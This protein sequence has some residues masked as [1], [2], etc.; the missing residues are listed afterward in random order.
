M[1]RWF[2]GV[3]FSL[4]VVGVVGCSNDS[5]SNS[6]PKADASAA[7]LAKAAGEKSEEVANFD[8]TWGAVSYV[9]NG[10]GEG[11]TGPANE[12]GVLWVFKGDKVTWLADVEGASLQG[13]F[14]LDP[15]SK[16]KTID[17]TFPPTPDFK[18]STTILGIYEIEGDTLK[19]CYGTDE[20]VKRP[21]EFKSKPKTSHVMIVFKKVE[22]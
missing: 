6:K 21:T 18:K 8:G 2:F 12:S 1:Q 22:K 5:V 15:K 11:E 14:K 20:G 9:E 7:G 3:L 17:F 4:V 19:I 10:H 13:S 16:P